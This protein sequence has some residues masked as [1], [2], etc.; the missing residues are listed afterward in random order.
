[1][2]KTKEQVRNEINDERVSA[3]FP[4][5]KEISITRCVIELFLSFMYGYA[6]GICVNSVTML[7][8]A[9]GFPVFVNFVV[10]LALLSIGV[11]IALDTAAPVVSAVYEA[12]AT[13]V[14]FV[15]TQSK[16]AWDFVSSN[17]VS[18]KQKYA[19]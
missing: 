4:E 8:V 3:L 5:F 15:G 17:V 14:Q 9:L 19:A 13:S 1:M 6:I 16:R 12:G 7:F 10:W 2:R 11:Y 18:L